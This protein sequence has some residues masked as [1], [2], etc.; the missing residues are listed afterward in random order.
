MESL[1]EFDRWLFFQ[2]NGWSN[3]ILDPIFYT[4]SSK[5][6]WIP[7]Y[8]F[9]AYLL[10]K[11]YQ[12]KTG[13]ILIL[14]AIISVTAS[15]LI[16][17]KIIKPEVG[18]YRP[19]HNI[20]LKDQVKVYVNSEG[21]EYR[22]G[23]YSFVSNHAANTFALITV[24]F[25]FLR[26]QIKWF[27]LYIFLWASIVCLSRVYLGVHYPSDIFGGALVGI[28]LASIFSIFALLIII[29]QNNKG[30]KIN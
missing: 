28:L 25:I 6:I 17:A 15:D 18:R 29:R 7:L 14:T 26:R 22:G 1:L 23:K 20:E 11:H 3:D 27:S 2:I 4:I 30:I 16:S 12:K 13:I 9:F 21:H 10:V 8:V 5:L 19:T 24:L